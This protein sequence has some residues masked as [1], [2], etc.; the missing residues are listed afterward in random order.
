MSAPNV[1]QLPRPAPVQGELEA[2]VVGA[3]LNLGLG[4]SE[5]EALGLA[6]EDFSVELLSRAWAIARRSAEAKKHVSAETVGSAGL[7][8]QWFTAGQCAELEKLANTS[9]LTLEAFR[10][11]AADLRTTVLRQRFIAR[12]QA[13]VR[14]AMGGQWSP[15]HAAQNLEG[16][17]SGLLRDTAP[18]EDASGDVVELLDGWDTNEKAGKSR[19]LPTRVA[20][21][22]A[23]YG[24]LPPGLTVF[25]SAPGVGK[26]AL[27]DSMIRAQLEADPE[28]HLGFF[29]LEDGTSHVARRWMAAD[30]GMLLRDIGWKQRTAEQ[31]TATEAA[32]ERFH[33]L[34]SRLHVY[35][36]DTITAS[37]LVARIASMRSKY[38]I[39]AA[40]VDN[41]TEVDF[42]QPRERQWQQQE[43][44][45]QAV[46]ELGRR[47]R[48][49]GLRE[50]MP[51]GL[52]A[53]T[54]GALKL[55]DIPT[56][57][58]LAGGQALG[59]RVR[60][61]CGLWAKGEEIRC[62]VSK[63]NE[64]GPSGITVS[65]ARLKTAGLIDPTQ[66]EKI[67]L[68]AERAIEQREKT[69]AKALEQEQAAEERRAR[70]AAKKAAADALKPKATEPVAQGV[71]LDVP[72]E[73]P[74]AAQ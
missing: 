74:D 57:N 61:F 26:T 69:K 29:G 28:L 64:L 13:E 42:S 19:L 68:Q 60:L 65:F 45:H 32:A 73:A 48:N 35:R 43:K 12:L 72:A 67:N 10:M 37:E 3:A 56:P 55:G 27:L 34:L 31:R 52:I 46:A 33:P 2:K 47:L 62:T 66:G 14:E 20:V 30:T 11:V 7:N 36:H 4:L 58:D 25:A 15:A 63:A 71:L 39:A 44:E 59:R 54:I 38:G 18:D 40:Y 41:L 5:F 6:R 49:Y 24:G 22:D 50:L 51:I 16:L 21:L 23:E 8:A 1:V 70:T 53:H 17:A 9:P